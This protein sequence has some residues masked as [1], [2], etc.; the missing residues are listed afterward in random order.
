M[1]YTDMSTSESET[2]LLCDLLSHLFELY[3]CD[4]LLQHPAT[5]GSDT[6]HELRSLAVQGAADII[7][8]F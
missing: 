5:A 1:F 2:K 7:V 6:N 4:C 8:S 3:G